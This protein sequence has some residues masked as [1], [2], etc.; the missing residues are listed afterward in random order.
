VVVLYST[1]TIK[2]SNK[3]LVKFIS[4]KK[5]LIFLI[6]FL[7]LTN[8]LC[9]QS[10][11][12]KFEVAQL[13]V[14]VADGTTELMPFFTIIPD[15]LNLDSA[16][17]DSLDL[18]SFPSIMYDDL[19]SV[20]IKNKALSV[21]ETIPFNELVSFQTASLMTTGNEKTSNFLKGGT[22]A[23]QLAVTTKS[24]QELSLMNKSVSVGIADPRINCAK[25]NTVYRKSCHNCFQRDVIPI[26]GGG[27]KAALGMTRV[28]ELDIYSSKV[29]G[30]NNAAGIW[31]VRHGPKIVNNNNNCQG[32]DRSFN[33]CLQDVIDWHND[34]LNS[35]HDPITIFIDLKEPT[36]TSFWRPGHNPI[37]LDNLLMTVGI[38]NIYTPKELGGSVI[39]LRNNA[40][41]NNWPSMGDLKDKFIF[42]LT[43]KENNVS[44]YLDARGIN[45]LA[46]IGKTASSENAAQ[47]VDGITDKEK[48]VFY[49]IRGKVSFIP[50]SIGNSLNQMN[51]AKLYAYPNNYISRVTT[52]QVSPNFSIPFNPFSGL[53]KP[54]DFTNKNY[55]K[56]IQ[57]QVNCPAPRNIWKNF[58]HYHDGDYFPENGMFYRPNTEFMLLNNNHIYSSHANVTQATTNAIVAQ[59][60][61]VEA[62]THYRMIAGNE[63]DLQP[64]VDFK[65]GSEVDVRIDNCEGADYSLRPSALGE[66]LTQEEI[67]VLMHEL[68]KELYNYQ[69]SDEKEVV[70]LSVYPNPT[71]TILNVSYTNYLINDGIFIL[72]DLTGRVVLTKNYQAQQKGKQQFNVN[73]NILK[74]GTYFYTLQVGEQNY[75][76]KVVKMD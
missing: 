38:Q 61:I 59:D 44:D 8:I 18:V 58:T 62:G 6:S 72:R 21:N 60:L 7:I 69:P 57:F 68:D 2:N 16:G 36:V 49:N 24:G 42:I 56:T 11:R 26:L 43:G 30:G 54:D 74:S 52:T 67:E 9:A 33:I 76:G 10:I 51:I 55:R 40:Q 28:I 3:A 37:D 17:I 73:I 13:S 53:F 41:K 64:G 71:T 34:P 25:F 66:Q 70:N 32:G 35:G 63:I 47:N 1:L 46:F 20:S 29:L 50:P 23:F 65:S 14:N 45:G 12:V 22:Y 15:T 31:N 48:V 75:N 4:M 19:A 5:Q 27:L 39:D